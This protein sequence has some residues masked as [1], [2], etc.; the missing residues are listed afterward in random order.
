MV[1]DEDYN[2]DEIRK[3]YPDFTDEELRMARDTFRRNCRALWRIA[4]RL[5]ADGK[6]IND[7]E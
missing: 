4:E 3:L 2:L 5:D 7:L 6:S 1:D